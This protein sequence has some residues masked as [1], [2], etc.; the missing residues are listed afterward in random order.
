[1]SEEVFAF[2]TGVVFVA[3]LGRLIFPPNNLS[4]ADVFFVFEGELQLKPVNRSERK[5]EIRQFL[6]TI[7]SSR[8]RLSES[9][10]LFARIIQTERLFSGFILIRTEK[11]SIPRFLEES[12]VF[13]FILFAHNFNF[14]PLEAEIMYFIMSL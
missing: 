7:T 12:Q 13:V 6:L 9:S 1:L 3:E 11:Y 8:S 14:T 4:A 2:M 10:A 5:S